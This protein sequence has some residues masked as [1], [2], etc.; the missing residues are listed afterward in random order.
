[1]LCLI[2]KL[3]LDSRFNANAKLDTVLVIASDSLWHT[4]CYRRCMA[5]RPFGVSEFENTLLVAS[6]DC[7]RINN[8][9]IQCIRPDFTNG[10]CHLRKQRGFTG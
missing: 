9:F 5:K 3:G 6:V 10:Q 1:M 4:K 7:N 8:Y 2:W